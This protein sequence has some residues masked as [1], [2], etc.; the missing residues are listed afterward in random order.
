MKPTCK[1]IT[2]Y[3]NKKLSTP[4]FRKDGTELPPC[5]NIGIYL[6]NLNQNTFNALKANFKIVRREFM[7]YVYFEK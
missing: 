3:V 6:P 5:N 2:E 4:T 1:N 7:G